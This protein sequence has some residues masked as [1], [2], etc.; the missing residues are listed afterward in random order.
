MKT[1]DFGF[2]PEMLLE[3]VRPTPKK[4]NELLKEIRSEFTEAEEGEDPKFVQLIV[5]ENTVNTFI[6]DFVLVERAFSLRN[7]MRTDPRFSEAL[8]QMTSDN[9]ALLMPEFGEEFGP[10]RAVDFYFSLS[11]SLIEKKIPD[12]KPSGF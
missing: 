3:G 5:D 8:R 10:G 9:V 7:F 2:D 12:P 4:K 1:L 11:H 6:L